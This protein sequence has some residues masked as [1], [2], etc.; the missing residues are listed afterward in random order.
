MRAAH[1]GAAILLLAGS[2]LA[3]ATVPADAS[4]TC[5]PS[6][7]LTVGQGG[8]DGGM[9]CPG[10]PGKP[11]DKDKTTWTKGGQPPLCVWVPQ[12]GYV[13]GPGE[14]VA[15]KDGQW[16]AHFCK[17]GQYATLA[18]FEAE[19]ATWDE[20]LSNMHQQ[21]LMRRA[22][23]EYRFFKTP[24]ETRPTAEQVMYWVAANLPFPATH[25]AV[26]PKPAANVVNMPTWVWLTDASGKYDPAAYAVQS[27]QVALFGY[28]LRWQIVPKITID[29]GD[30]GA[31]QSCTGIGVPWS[32]S[33]DAAGACTVSYAKS[34]R[35]TLTATVSWTV[36]WW[37]G[38]V[39]QGDIEGP[40]NLATSVITV[41]EIQVVGR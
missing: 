16:Y 23:I 24:P 7:W 10:K 32:Q 11:G 6:S 37:L 19:M 29:P 36:Q 13:P 14:P 9:Q 12:P 2:L 34:G 5:D 4:A 35:Y 28:P 26:N 27:K 1:A 15:G 3:A 20:D 25:V 33:A 17:F 30:G 21:D 39:P 18:Q 8:T 22:G 41:N 31:A 38:G 40:D